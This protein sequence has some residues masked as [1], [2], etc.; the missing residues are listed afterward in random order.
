MSLVLQ[1]EDFPLWANGELVNSARGGIVLTAR[2]Y[3]MA[4]DIC[5]RLN[6]DHFGQNTTAA[7]WREREA[8]L[9]SSAISPGSLVFVGR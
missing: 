2:D 6:R 9:E 5:A 7:P 8:A 3:I 1:I 4:Q